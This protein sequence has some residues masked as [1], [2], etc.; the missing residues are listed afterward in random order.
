[1][2]LIHILWWF[3]TIVKPIEEVGA[4]VYFLPPYSPDFNPIEELFSKVKTTLKSL[5]L[6]QETQY[7]Q[8]FDLETLLL[9]SFTSITDEDCNAWIMDS[10]IYM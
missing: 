9:A 2:A 1:M 6:Q 10:A 8:R 7:T 3:S 4:L 5:E